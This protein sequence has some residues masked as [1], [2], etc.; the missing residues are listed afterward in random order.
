L[1]VLVVE[2]AEEAAELLKIL[3]ELWGHDVRVAHDGPAA[4]AAFRIHQPEVILL[5]IGLPGM[6]GYDVA[7]QLRQQQGRNRP[8][9]VALTGYGGEEDKRRSVAAGCDSH[10][11]KPPDPNRLQLLLTPSRAVT[12]V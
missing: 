3:L 1:R 10:L 7:A 12:E 9:I 4:L 11:T 5:D 8:L 2:D 6:N